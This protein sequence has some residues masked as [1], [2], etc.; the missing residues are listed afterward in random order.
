MTV[1]RPQNEAGEAAQEQT[2]RQ[3]KPRKEQPDKWHF[4]RETD[5]ADEPYEF[6]TSKH[7]D[8]DPIAFVERSE[9]FE[10]G[11][12]VLCKKTR[13][14]GQIVT[15]FTHTKTTRPE[16]TIDL[17]D[18][19]DEGLDGYSYSS[20][21]AVD[22]DERTARIVAATVRALRQEDE[23][24]ERAT[25]N[26]P[27]A[28]EMV[29]KIDEMAARRAAQLQSSKP[30]APEQP[31]V[32]TLFEKLLGL[33]QKLAPQQADVDPEDRFLDRLQKYSKV[34]KIIN[35]MQA[36]LEEDEGVIGKAGKVIRELREIAPVVSPL[37]Q[38]WMLSRAAKNGV[39]LPVIQPPP[40]SESPEPEQQQQATPEAVS[41]EDAPLTLND[42]VSNIK[43]A[44]QANDKPDECVN[45]VAMFVS[46]NPAYAVSVEQM[47]GASNGELMG[48]I[49]AHT[50]ADVSLLA[51]ANKFLDGLRKGVRARLRPQPVPSPMV[52][53]N[54]HSSTVDME[55]VQAS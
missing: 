48:L 27:S 34:A 43:I 54:G 18:T 14:S 13:A 22:E 3:R 51:N 45:D 12:R 40:A 35:P 9:D 4:S 31:D 20:G 8:I 25:Q 15:S 6:V 29:E 19:G 49:A 41:D 53:N 16:T 10:E 55:S 39:Q 38:T 23:R 5:D 37:I 42:I 30:T 44:I 1:Q 33:Q 7:G 2:A 50:G 47:M 26:Q 46:D 21:R 36:G 17:D 32:F 28:L 52:S 24:R 11:W